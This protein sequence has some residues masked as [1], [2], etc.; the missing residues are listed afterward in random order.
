M[1]RGVTYS[2]LFLGS[3]TVIGSV[4]KRFEKGKVGGRK[5]AATD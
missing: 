1:E 3:F 4:K 2:F 5:I